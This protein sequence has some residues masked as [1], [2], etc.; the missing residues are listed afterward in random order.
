[1]KTKRIIVLSLIAVILMLAILLAI[2]WNDIFFC[3]IEVGMNVD[4]IYQTVREDKYD[5]VGY[6]YIYQNNLNDIVI[7]CTKQGSYQIT[8]LQYVPCWTTSRSDAAF[9]KLEQGMTLYEVTALIGFPDSTGG[10]GIQSST[11]YSNSGDAYRVSWFKGEVG[12]QYIL[13]WLSKNGEQIIG[14]KTE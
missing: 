8:D 10:S 5:I 1:M 6:D 2:F 11:Y 7:A 13:G 4:V 14:P 9:S 12:T 3:G